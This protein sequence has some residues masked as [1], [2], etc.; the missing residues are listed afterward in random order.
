MQIGQS[1]L[2]YGRE[3]SVLGCD[4]FTRNFLDAKGI[5]AAKNIHCPEGP[6]E[7]AVQV[8]V[9]MFHMA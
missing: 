8:F 4:D 9:S 7:Q 1:L 2:L 5:Q 3:F 6:Y